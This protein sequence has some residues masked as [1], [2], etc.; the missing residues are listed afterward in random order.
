MLISNVI[1]ET[2]DVV[3]QVTSTPEFQYQKQETVF[4]TKEMFLRMLNSSF[5]E[6]FLIVRAKK[7]QKM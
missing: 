7:S 6:V 4:E 2:S 5:L 3:K 1:S